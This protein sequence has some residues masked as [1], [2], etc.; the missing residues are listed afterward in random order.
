MMRK[1][2]IFS[3]DRSSCTGCGACSQICKHDALSM[4]ADDEGFLYPVLNTQKC[5]DCGL[6]DLTCPVVNSVT[7][8]QGHNQHCYVATVFDKNVYQESA[9]IG[10]CTLLSKYIIEIGGV[11]FGVFL[12]ENNW[13]AYHIMIEDRNALEKIRNSKYLQSSTS[14]TFM[15]VKQLLKTNKPVLYI[16]TPCQIA[17]LKSFLKV[18]YN[19]LY[20]IDLICHG[21]FSPKLMP[22]EIKYWESKYNGK[23]SNF[24]FRSKRVYKHVNGG[25]VNFDIM[26]N[27]NLKHIER[28]AASSPTYRCYAYAGDGFFYNHRISCYNCSFRSKKR[29]ADIT[30]GDPWFIRD[31][32][33]STPS[34]RSCNVIRSLF[35]T[36]TKKGEFLLSAIKNYLRIEELEIDKSFC[37]PAVLPANN[38]IPE[39]R[40]ILFSC[41]DKEDYG[42]LVERLLN[43]NLD[44]AQSKFEKDY[45]IKILKR[46]LKKFFLW[47]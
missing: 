24:R 6:C 9:S 15:R 20:T 14:D 13:R 12:D 31:D 26:N 47:S 42:A 27:G 4:N 23:I 39:K 32:V 11:V 25:M 46:I 22:L 3:G 18:S 36:N 29:Y 5:I 45:K 7:E 17:G 8:N 21:V 16:G 37:Q 19:N 28:Y 44:K 35:S 41:I 30:V 1:S 38:V 43:C 10:I 34:L 33:I 40:K 2:F